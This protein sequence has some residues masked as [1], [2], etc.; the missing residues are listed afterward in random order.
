MTETSDPER[1]AVK[2]GACP[3]DRT[4]VSR[5]ARLVR[6]TATRSRVSSTIRPSVP[7]GGLHKENACTSGL[8]RISYCSENIRVE[9]QPGSRLKLIDPVPVMPL[10]KR[11]REILTFLTGYTEANGYAPSFEEIAA[12]FN[13]NSLATVHEH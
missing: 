6:S 12:Q 11:Q 5:A 7:D 8:V 9:A 13:Y 1:A 10:T 3:A 4:A 2:E